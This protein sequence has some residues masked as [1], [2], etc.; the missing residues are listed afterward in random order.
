MVLNLNYRL[1]ILIK[2][3]KT[4]ETKSVAMN[5]FELTAVMVLNSVH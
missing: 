4:N 2:L 1:A 3:V 5:V